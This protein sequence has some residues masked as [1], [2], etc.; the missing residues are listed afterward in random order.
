MYHFQCSNE[1]RFG[2]N[3][4]CNDVRRREIYERVHRNPAAGSVL[5]EGEWLLSF[6]F[7]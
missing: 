6:L 1:Y 4:K 2:K 3:H 7:L 5:R